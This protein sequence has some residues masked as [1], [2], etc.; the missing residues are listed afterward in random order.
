MSERVKYETQRE[1][2][3]AWLELS[4]IDPKEVTDVTVQIIA[5][6]HAPQSSKQVLAAIEENPGLLFKYSIAGRLLIDNFIAVITDH[7]ANQLAMKF[8]A[9]LQQQ[10]MEKFRPQLEIATNSIP[11]PS[12]DELAAR[13]SK[14]SLT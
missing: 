10:Q 8:Q 6:N 14:K 5:R 13:R 9:T 12:V 2:D 4:K 3:L 7:I 11:E 1:I